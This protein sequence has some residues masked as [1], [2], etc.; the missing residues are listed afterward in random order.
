[1][2]KHANLHIGWNENSRWNGETDVFWFTISHCQGMSSV[3]DFFKRQHVCSTLNLQRAQVLMDC[4]CSRGHQD[5]SHTDMNM[6]FFAFPASFVEKKHMILGPWDDNLLSIWTRIDAIVTSPRTDP[7][8][9]NPG[10]KYP[11]LTIP[12]ND[13]LWNAV[14]QTNEQFFVAPKKAASKLMEVVVG[15]YRNIFREKWYR[16]RLGHLVSFFPRGWMQQVRSASPW[17]LT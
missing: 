3:F 5:H 17:K 8:K 13:G 15:N 2:K 16:S 1:M 14:I 7:K 10:G 4:R 11:H 6:T 12:E 9:Q